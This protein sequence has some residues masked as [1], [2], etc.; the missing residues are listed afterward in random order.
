MALVVELTHEAGQ[1]IKANAPGRRKW[2]SDLPD[3]GDLDRIGLDSSDDEDE[4]GD[5]L[6]APFQKAWQIAT[7][8]VA[9]AEL[10]QSHGAQRLGCQEEP[11]AVGYSGP[12]A[13]LGFQKPLHSHHD[14]GDR[15]P[16]VHD[17]SEES[18]C[19][20]AR[21]GRIQ[22]FARREESSA[23]G[24]GSGLGREESGVTEVLVAKEHQ[25]KYVETCWNI[26]RCC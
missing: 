11:A 19:R 10:L 26:P 25:L 7:Q 2:K 21:T 6:Y 23:S 15:G 12:R 1:A 4:K 14:F 9:Q 20:R 8:S 22:T 13:Q 16:A 24:T 5:Q 3:L 17:Q 18:G